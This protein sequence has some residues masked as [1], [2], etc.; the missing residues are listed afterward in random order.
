MGLLDGIG[1]GQ[2]GQ[3]VNIPNQVRIA[4]VGVG[5]GGNSVVGHLMEHAVPGIEYYCVNTDTH[6]LNMFP[7]ARMIQIGAS[8]T[9]GFGAGG[10]PEVGLKA[11]KESEEMLGAALRGADLVFITAGMGGGTGTGAAPLVAEIAKK[12]GALVVGLVTTPFSFEGHRRLDIA[13]A[14]AQRLSEKVDNLIIIH[15]DR[16]LQLVAKDTDVGSAFRR[17]DEAVT[18]GILAVAEL[19]NVPAQINVDFADVRAI[20]SIHGR[21]LMAVGFGE[22]PN[23]ALEA[24]RQAVENPLI[25]VSILRAAGVLFQVVGGPDLTLGQVNNVGN[26]I[27][28]AVDRDA[29]VFFGMNIAP[30][31]QGRARITIIATGIPEGSRSGF[32]PG[33]FAGDNARREPVQEAAKSAIGRDGR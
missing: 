7:K 3:A 6:A 24:A 1:T 26:L 27:S 22:G 17:A 18:Q 2:Q 21:S 15:N 13:M 14:G 29:I 20:L 16:L 19:V 30:E 33:Q 11:A 32:A 8:V 5:G 25:D 12:S 23:G 31:M 28:K 10:D 4:V 9:R